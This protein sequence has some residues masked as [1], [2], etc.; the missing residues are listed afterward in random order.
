MPVTRLLLLSAVAAGL[1]GQMASAE[2]F[3]HLTT[4]ATPSTYDGPCPIEIKLES[5]IEFDAG[6]NR[7]QVF[8]YRWENGSK[9]L[10]DVLAT[11]SKETGNRVEATTLVQGPVG[12]KIAVP[13]RLHVTTE[14]GFA[15]TPSA[16][17]GYSS[18]AIVTVTCRS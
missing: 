14:A 12:K 6:F 16:S 7:Q 10:T 13:V 4:S 18:P 5:V 11:H 8:Y 2:M 3:D 9:V 15:K 1:S 17:D